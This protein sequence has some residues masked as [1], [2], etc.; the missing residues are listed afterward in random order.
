MIII[1]KGFRVRTGSS[2]DCGRGRKF[3]CI[4]YLTEIQLQS[5]LADHKDQIRVYAYAYHD[6]DV[7]EDGTIKEP[8]CHIVFVT[9]SAHSLSAVRRWFKGVDA[10]G[11][12]I[13]TTAQICS[14]VYSMYDY[15]TH[16]TSEAIAGGKYRYDNSIIV[17]NDKDGYFQASQSS[18]YDNLTLAAEMILQGRY[19]RDVMRVFGRDFIIHYS[20]IE[21]LVFRILEQRRTHETLEQIH[22]KEYQREL[23]KLN[24][25][26]G[27]NSDDMFHY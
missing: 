8:H 1:S 19:L 16:S 13:T 7:R 10:S 4:T 11:K 27:S 18:D 25:F 9:Y 24:G 5:R 2:P 6:K 26:L 22:E 23:D 14:D 15:L 17:T 21:K 20:S 12:D 3:S